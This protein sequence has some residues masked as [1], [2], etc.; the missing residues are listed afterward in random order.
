MQRS[1]TQASG[2]LFDKRYRLIDHMNG[3]VELYDHA[4]PAETENVAEANPDV[5]QK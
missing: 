3:Y 1:H 4:G 2:R 5:V